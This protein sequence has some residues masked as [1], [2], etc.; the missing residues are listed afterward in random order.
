MEEDKPPEFETVYDAVSCL[1]K[2]Y[3][4][5][6]GS[7]SA[8]GMGYDG[9]VEI[10]EKAPKWAK[11][12]ANSLCYEPLYCLEHPTIPNAYEY[13][14]FEIYEEGSRIYRS[15]Y[16]SSQEDRYEVANPEAIQNAIKDRLGTKTRCATYS[17]ETSKLTF[18]Y[19]AKSQSYECD[20]S[21][22][23]LVDENEDGD[24]VDM[25]CT[26]EQALSL[27]NVV[28]PLLDTYPDFEPDPTI[29]IFFES[30][31]SWLEYTIEGSSKPQDITDNLKSLSMNDYK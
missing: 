25:E 24:S 4:F 28:L 6:G 30:L 12:L 17:D 29:S 21:E 9:E 27:L 2:N 22:F 5:S 16:W 13:V 3:G 26:E 14:Y 1:I 11:E 10:S 20:V 23:H 31:E 19:N 15:N 18:D 8:A 7:I